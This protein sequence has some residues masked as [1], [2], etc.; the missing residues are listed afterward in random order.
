MAIYRSLARGLVTGLGLGW[1][2]Y[3]VRRR[4][5][6][7]MLGLPPAGYEVGLAANLRLPMTDGLTLA[8][9]HYFPME[10][11]NFPTILI[12]TP[13]GK[14][15]GLQFSAQ[16]FAERGYHVLVQD[17]RG[18]FDSDGERFVPFV[19]EQ[20][21]GLATLAWLERQSWFNGR[22][23]M[24]GR[25][26]V[27]YCQWAVATAGPPMLKAIVPSITST[28]GFA[29]ALHNYVFT[30][31]L[32]FRW[33][34]LLDAMDHK[35]RLSRWEMLWRAL[36]AGQRQILEPA[37]RHLP[38]IEAD[39][40]IVGREI[41]D[42]RHSLADSNGHGWQLTDHS[43]KIGNV[44]APAHLIGGW[45]D[46][47]LN[48][49]LADYAALSEAG[50]QPYL[51]IGPWHHLGASNRSYTFAL[52]FD[53]FETHLKGL[54]GRLRPSPVRVYVMGLKQW[55]NLSCWP[56]A[57]T[58][59]TYFLHP[60]RFLLQKEPES[61]AVPSQYVYDPAD[62]TP[63]VGGP[64]LYNGAGPKDNRAVEA[65]P[66]LLTFS[67]PPLTRPVT[68]MGPVRLT[69][70]VQSSVPFT[71]FFAR[72]CV[73][74]PDGQSLNVCD[75]I[76]RVVPG[77]GQPQ[78]DGSLKIELRLWD[79]AYSFRPGQAIR[80]QIASAN[81]PRFARN[82]GYGE[83]LATAVGMRPAIQTIYHDETHPSA[84]HFNLMD[85]SLA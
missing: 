9:D 21:D 5:F 60:G 17:V 85:D 63:T 43:D 69:L 3:R 39:Q 64:L 84:L 70:Y 37:F 47:F 50:Q 68:I 26:Y 79:T 18:R 58:L 52:E 14:R 16:R 32:S 62:P 81:H 36:P 40:L 12:R 46:I 28:R 77:R 73:V 80:L 25:S 10:S 49:L 55:R 66:D 48:D 1:L 19:H 65:R 13:Y 33:L 23:G 71:D 45:Y 29:T 34:L 74:L 41:P 56:P 35:G 6:G 83:P 51:T 57:G 75:G 59:A 42:F 44:T 11:G 4:L 27:G 31:D 15:P 30:L 8:T 54:P 2:A 82:L 22:L 78:A 61:R 72:L 24:W 38:L 67:T 7:L 20:D 76:Y 53:W